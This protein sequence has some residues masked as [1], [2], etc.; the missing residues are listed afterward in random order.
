MVNTFTFDLL[1]L[2][3]SLALPLHPFLRKK[4]ETLLNIVSSSLG[5]MNRYWWHTDGRGNSAVAGL[6][7]E[8]L[9]KLS[10]AC[11]PL[12]KSG[13]SSLFLTKTNFLFSFLVQKIFLKRVKSLIHPTFSDIIQ[14]FRSN[15][16]RMQSWDYC[17]NHVVFCH[18]HA[19]KLGICNK[20]F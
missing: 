1:S 14:M 12:I 3:W 18:P 5:C 6:S 13:N 2:S 17:R 10:F 16:T 15:W 4:K 19:S 8:R 11:H 9:L 20:Y 7:P